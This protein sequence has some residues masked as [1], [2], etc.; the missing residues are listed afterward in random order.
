MSKKRLVLVVLIVFLLFSLIVNAQSKELFLDRDNNLVVVKLDQTGEIISSEAGK[1]GA[2][3]ETNN[4]FVDRS[5]FNEGISIKGKDSNPF[6]ILIGPDLLKGS[7]ALSKIGLIKENGQEFLVIHSKESMKG[8]PLKIR[9]TPDQIINLEGKKELKVEIKKRFVEDGQLKG[10][11][12]IAF[13]DAL[14]RI[15]SINFDTQGGVEYLN[16]ESGRAASPT[17]VSLGSFAKTSVSYP[18]LKKASMDIKKIRSGVVVSYRSNIE[19]S[20]D[21]RSGEEKLK[22]KKSA[23]VISKGKVLLKEDMVDILTKIYETNFGEIP[24]EYRTILKNLDSYSKTMDI[25]IGERG[26]IV[27][28]TGIADLNSKLQKDL[29]NYLEKNIKGSFAFNK[30]IEQGRLKLLIDNIG[31]PKVLMGKQPL[32]KSFGKPLEIHAI[33]LTPKDV[34]SMTGEKLREIGSKVKS[35]TVQEVEVGGIKKEK[36]VKGN[37]VIRVEP[38]QNRDIMQNFYQGL[39]QSVADADRKRRELTTSEWIVTKSFID[40][41]FP[42]VKN[43][44]I[45]SRRGSEFILPTK[46]ENID[47][48]KNILQQDGGINEVDNLEELNIIHI[49][50]NRNLQIEETWK[51]EIITKEGKREIVIPKSDLSKFSSLGR[52]IQSE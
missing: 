31:N 34:A 14:E 10:E 24:E 11:T 16:L 26:D 3:Y 5:S 39:V 18:I 4:L 32:F 42:G 6:Q 43:K 13:E 28:G 21:I 46:E 25:M 48:I 1:Y 51:L 17:E 27:I 50:P 7:G 33:D 20:V 9:I 36:E 41:A 19:Q 12:K 35:L 52:Y 49:S 8:E 23:R 22:T 38:A 45:Y 44:K 37:P 15:Y 47:E 29:D 40:T 2:I 30:I